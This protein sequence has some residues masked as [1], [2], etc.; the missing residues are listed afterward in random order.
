MPVTVSVYNEGKTPVV[1]ERAS[2]SMQT[3]TTQA[4]RAILPDSVARQ[5]LTYR[6]GSNPTLP[7]WLVRAT[8]RRHVRRAGAARVRRAANGDRRG[9]VRELW[10]R[11]RAQDRRRADVPVRTGPIV[12]RFADPARGEVRRP[13]AVVPEISVLLRHDVEYARG[14]AAVR[15]SDG[16]HASARWR[17]RRA[18][19]TSRSAF[20]RGCVPIPPCGT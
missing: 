13:I 11:R 17:P 19:S 3:R 16:R 10:R 20:R 18:T 6:A 14:N 12:Y 9:S 15:S 1:L 4:P 5:T 2:I 8:A 7:W